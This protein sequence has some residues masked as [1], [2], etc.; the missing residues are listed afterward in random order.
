MVKRYKLGKKIS[1][2]VV[3]CW[4]IYSIIRVLIKFIVTLISSYFTLPTKHQNAYSPYCAL[5]KQNFSDI[6][7]FLLS[8]VDHFVYSDSQSWSFFQGW[9]CKADASHSWEFNGQGGSE[10]YRMEFLSWNFL[11]NHGE[12]IF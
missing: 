4:K 11:C 2:F 5:Y 12:L 1:M 7:D 9:Y 6:R 3:S 10:S 8:V